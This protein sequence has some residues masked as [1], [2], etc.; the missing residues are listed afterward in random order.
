[1]VAAKIHLV[2]HLAVTDAK[3][4][5]QT[6]NLVRCTHKFVLNLHAKKMKHI[7]KSKYALIYFKGSPLY[8]K[9]NEEHSTHKYLKWQYILQKYQSSDF[10]QLEC[11]NMY[12]T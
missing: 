12:A 7:N 1:M 2:H 3:I 4:Q 9:C 5:G 10:V 6:R 8:I 11:Q